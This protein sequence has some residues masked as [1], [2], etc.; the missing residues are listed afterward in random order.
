M[1]LIVESDD[2]LHR[3]GI[4]IRSPMGENWETPEGLK[5][6]ISWIESELLC[7]DFYQCVSCNVW[8]PKDFVLMCKDDG[9]QCIPCI[10]AQGRWTD[11][12]RRPLHHGED[13]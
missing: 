2:G 4:R 3:R 5:D 7:G 9:K 12:K 11:P 6:V 10:E 13:L 8:G 1:K